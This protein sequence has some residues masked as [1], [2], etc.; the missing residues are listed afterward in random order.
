V[1][2]F[3][4]L[5]AAIPPTRSFFEVLVDGVSITADVYNAQL[6]IT[7]GDNIT[8]T[9]FPANDTIRF[10]G[11]AAVGDNLGN[12]IPTQTINMTN[13]Q[14][15]LGRYLDASPPP[16]TDANKGAILYNLDF[17]N[18]RFCDGSSWSNI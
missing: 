17:D 7:E 2:Y 6:N 14:I 9:A 16:C 4:V 13:Q 5:D 8:I 12:H 3:P 11:V 10:D 15:I 1:A 18:V